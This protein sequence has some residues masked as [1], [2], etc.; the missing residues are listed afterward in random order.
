MPIIVYWVRRNVMDKS[1]KTIRISGRCGNTA[2]DTALVFNADHESNALLFD[3]PGLVQISSEDAEDTAAG[4]GARMIEI[5]GFDTQ[6]AII[7][8]VLST[9]GQTAVPTTKEF[10]SIYSVRVLDAGS[11]GSNDGIVFV[12]P[13]GT[14]LTAGVPNGETIITLIDIGDGT[15]NQWQMKVPVGHRAKINAGSA[16][17][18]DMEL[19]IQVRR[20]GEAWNTEIRIL[21]NIGI[22]TIGNYP[23]GT[24]VRI[25]Y[26][27][28]VAGEFIHAAIDFTFTAK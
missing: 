18:D 3:T 20:P 4:N 19:R 17:T 23:P 15:A 25:Q 5:K 13:A 8:E 12:S 1:T 11:S 2:A 6:G 10:D 14:A 16:S 26:I 24:L 22:S 27:S 21:S 28:A 9:N 7:E